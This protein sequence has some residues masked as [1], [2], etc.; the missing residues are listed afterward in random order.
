VFHELTRQGGAGEGGPLRPSGP[1][2]RARS[3]ASAAAG[4]EHKVVSMGM[5]V[6]AEHEAASIGGQQAR[7]ARRSEHEAASMGMQQVWSM[8][9]HL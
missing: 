6:G 8:K 1:C 9:L 7:S 2:M 3:G 5:T 4:A